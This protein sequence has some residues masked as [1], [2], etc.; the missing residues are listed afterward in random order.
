LLVLSDTTNTATIIYT[1]LIATPSRATQ[2]INLPFDRPVAALF[3]SDGN[4]AYIVNCGPECGGTQASVS[5]VDLSPLPANP[6]LLG[7]VQVPAATV[8]L[9]DG[10]T[11]YVA[12]T[13]PTDNSC[14]AAGVSVCGRLTPVNLAGLTA[15]TSVEIPNGYHDTLALGANNLLFAGATGCTN[16]MNGTDPTR[17]CLAVYDIQNQS[18]TVTVANGDVTGIQPIRNRSRVYVAQGGELIMYDTTTGLPLDS[19]KQTIVVGQAFDV[20]LID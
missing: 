1:S 13:S 4:T 3:S 5:V 16:L 9:L 8:A 10:T 6:V 15:G 12:G 2:V 11:L 20:K 14:T 7:D 17:G 19:T 18:T